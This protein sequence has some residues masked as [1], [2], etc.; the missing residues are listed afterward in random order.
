[1]SNIFFIEFIKVLIQL[2]KIKKRIV[3]KKPRKIN[4]DIIGVARGGVHTN[5]KGT[6]LLFDQIKQ[7]ISLEWGKIYFL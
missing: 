2:G 5:H 3:S 4:G 1:M 6:P 7:S